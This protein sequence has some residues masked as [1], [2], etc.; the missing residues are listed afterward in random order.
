MEPTTNVNPDIG[1]HKKD[2]TLGLLFKFKEMMNEHFKQADYD[3]NKDEELLQL[4]KERKVSFIVVKSDG[5][6]MYGVKGESE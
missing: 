6:V 2:T 3:P 5:V 1:V 4:A